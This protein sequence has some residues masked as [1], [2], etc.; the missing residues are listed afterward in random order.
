M[1]EFSLVKNLMITRFGLFTDDGG[2]KADFRAIESYG[3]FSVNH[4]FSPCND[5]AALN[6]VQGS[7]V[8]KEV[9]LSRNRAR[10]RR[11]LEA[12]QVQDLEALRKE[13]L[14]AD[15]TD[16][17]PPCGRDISP[18]NR[19]FHR[20]TQQWLCHVCHKRAKLNNDVVVS[21]QSRKPFKNSAENEQEDFGVDWCP[22]NMWD[23]GVLTRYWSEEIGLWICS[24]HGKVAV[25][26]LLEDRPFRDKCGG[27]GLTGDN[28]QYLINWEPNSH[29]WLCRTCKAGRPKKPDVCQT[30]WCNRKALRWRED[31]HTW[32]CPG[33]LDPTLSEINEKR[34][35]RVKCEDCGKSNTSVKLRWHEPI[36]QWLC[37]D[38]F[39]P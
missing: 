13:R 11:H 39:D 26:N 25:E 27:C 3:I 9:M 24:S 16:T 36:Q 1:E 35:L 17:C 34:S 8:S 32:V 19:V 15:E 37:K 31:N 5:K 12:E 22:Q 23:Y 21:L 29:R 10:D 33:C 14:A 18:N 2:Q 28:I 20:V 6:D 4:D 30:S 7:L 38:C